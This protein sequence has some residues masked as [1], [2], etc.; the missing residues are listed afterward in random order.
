MSGIPLQR[1][2]QSPCANN[3]M[4]ASQ[5]HGFL[6]LS[7]RRRR[8][9][10]PADSCPLSL[11][12]LVMVSPG[13][14]EYHATTDARLWIGNFHALLLFKTDEE[15]GIARGLVHRMVERAIALEGT[16]EREYHLVAK[17]SFSKTTLSG[18]GEHGVGIGKREYLY[19]E[20]GAGTVELMKTIKK[21]LDPL[22]LFNPGKVGLRLSSSS[23]V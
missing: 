17:I 2:I 3:G 13:G 4:V 10:S 16:C 14:F 15:L 5:Y 7:T 21:T 9:S 12:T 6:I 8:I 20:L 1:M 22:N 18:T 23:H 19:S 11:G